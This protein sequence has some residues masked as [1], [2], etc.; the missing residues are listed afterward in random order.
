MK[1]SR[2]F[3]SIIIVLINIHVAFGEAE[4]NNSFVN[5][6][7]IT[8]DGGGGLISGRIQTI[9][10]VDYFKFVVNEGSLLNILITDIPAEIK[11]K[12]VLYSEDFSPIDSV[13]GQNNAQLNL[14]FLVC[15]KNTYYI[16]FKDSEDARHNESE[17]YKIEIK[18]GNSEDPSECNNT[19]ETATNLP[20]NESL[21]GAIQNIGD[22]DWYK[23]EITKPGVFKI[24]FT[25]IPAAILP[26]ITLVKSNSQSVVKEGKATDKTMSVSEF[27]CDLGMYYVKFQDKLNSSE[28][29]DK[30]KIKITH[31]T[32]DTYECNNSIE[33]AAPIAM[34]KELSAYLQ[35]ESDRDFYVFELGKAGVINVE[36]KNIPSNIT[37]ILGLY[38]SNKAF[39]SEV[40]GVKGDNSISIN[41]FTCK[42]GKFYF[43]FRDDP[44]NQWNDL[45]YQFSAKNIVVDGNECNDT[46]ETA[47]TVGLNQ[48]IKGAIQ[49]E[50]D[51]D[52]YAINLA[53]GILTI[54][55][56]DIPAGIRPKIE[57]FDPSEN[58]VI[59]DTV[60]A[61][62]VPF[63]KTKKM[64]CKDGKYLLMIRD[65]SGTGVDYSQYQVTMTLKKVDGNECNNTIPTATRIK[66]GQALR[67]YIDLKGDLDYYRFDNNEPGVVSAKVTSIS[68]RIQPQLKAFDSS[69]K[70]LAMNTGVKGVNSITF[71]FA[72]CEDPQYYVMFQDA[73][74]GG[75]DENTPYEVVL[76]H[77]TLE[78][79]ECN[80]AL[81]DAT[82]IIPSSVVRASIRPKGDFDYYKFNLTKDLPYQLFVDLVPKSINMAASLYTPGIDTPLFTRTAAN[83]DS[84]LENFSVPLDGEYILKLEDQLGDSSSSAAYYL[85]IREKPN[86]MVEGKLNAL[87]F[88]PNPATDNIYIEGLAQGEKVQILD[89]TGKIVLETRQTTINIRELNKGIYLLKTKQ[90]HARL[91]RD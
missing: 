38:D 8:S 2:I 55:L 25:E 3:F 39:I 87:T 83:G 10:D 19:K 43:S 37:P 88:Y 48:S 27:T 89:L 81:E 65:L 45:P 9:G 66:V 15:Q 30:Y 13:V 72:T 71:E 18:F 4:P 47:T 21:E 74:G 57:L 70:L 69:G 1:V 6:N 84:I 29:I 46:K 64:I 63:I 90:G 78:Q 44:N 33:T 53:S 42:K 56:K 40:K 51:I 23:F 49:S 36:V 67:G 41:H 32:N 16:L 5:A 79:Y 35:N 75:E 28:S 50:G 77:E 85:L 31:N 58:K 82:K 52:Y 12:L 91:I 11:A 60:V 73:T 54:D 34:E 76:S 17:F 80:N 20:I 22:V 14:K 62:L 59:L 68:P 61:A 86:G 7:E 24:E 26:Q